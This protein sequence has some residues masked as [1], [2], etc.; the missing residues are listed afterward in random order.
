M[1]VRE[2]QQRFNDEFIKKR[3]LLMLNAK[4]VRLV[5]EFYHL[6]PDWQQVI[7]FSSIL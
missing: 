7:V 4:D 3:H 1:F 6:Q 5:H 2:D